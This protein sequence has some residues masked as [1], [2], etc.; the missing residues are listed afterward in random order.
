M[1]GVF[2]MRKPHVQPLRKLRIERS[3][4]RKEEK[5]Y[6]KKREEVWIR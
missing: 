1:I 3:E 2:N 5:E 4:K 6:T